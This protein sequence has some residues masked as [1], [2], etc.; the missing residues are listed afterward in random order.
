M[1]QDQLFRDLGPGIGYR[2]RYTDDLLQGSDSIDWVEALTENYFRIAGERELGA[3]EK[4]ER[5]RARYPVV[6][7]GVSL[8]LGSTDPLEAAYL[9]Q[10]KEL[11]ERIQ[12]EWVSDHLCWT[13]VDGKNLHDLL[14]LPYTT[15][16]LDHVVDRISR[17]QDFLGRRILVENVSSYVEFKSNEMPEWEFVRAVAEKADCGIL[18]DINNVYVSSVNHGFSAKDYLRAI[19]IERVGQIHLAGYTEKDGYLVDTHSKPVAEPV[20]ELYRWFTSQCTGISTMIEWDSEFP[21]WKTLCHEV[22]KIRDIKS[23]DSQPLRERAAWI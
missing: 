4:L 5:I 19:P 23:G 1:K 8:S 18:L 2:W 14:P 7:H 3:I 17:V 10:W 11:I 13:G 12:P 21:E 16:A 15:H 9:K 6:L 20:W 22:E